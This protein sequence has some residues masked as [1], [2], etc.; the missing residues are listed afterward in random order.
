MGDRSSCKWLA[1]C[2]VL[3][4]ELLAVI[5]AAAGEE[6]NSGVSGSPIILIKTLGETST[7]LLQER[8]KPTGLGETGA[9]AME[10]RDAAAKLRA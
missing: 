9:L 5:K 4:C 2:S 10:T 8:N 1:A 3:G 6:F 7:E